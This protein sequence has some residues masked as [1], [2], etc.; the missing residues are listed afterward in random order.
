MPFNVF[1]KGINGKSYILEDV[2]PEMT[3]TKI[4]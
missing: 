4:K 3:V 1:V 2:T